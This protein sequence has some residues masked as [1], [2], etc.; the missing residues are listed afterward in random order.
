M[1]NKN[2]NVMGKNSDSSSSSIN[3]IGAGTI[4]NGEVISNGDIRVDGTV[5]GSVSSKG[6][7][8]IGSTGNV[9]GEIV[10]QNADVSGK[11]SGNI[12]VAEILS[13][14]ATAN[15]IGDI[16]ASKLSIEP[17]AN[18]MGSCSMGGMVK[19]IVNADKQEREKAE[20]IA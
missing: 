15:L 2:R 4:I 14:K 18:F 20:K 13:L 8:V 3:L 5:V 19:N 1:F 17:G 9:E 7:V 6:K 16:I 10:C 12:S 11:I